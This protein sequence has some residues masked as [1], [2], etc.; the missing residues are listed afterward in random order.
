MTET[1]QFFFIPGF[2]LT[3]QMWAPVTRVL[4]E[5]ATALEIPGGLDFDAVVRSLAT[6]RTGIWVGY[7]M[8]GRI[9]LRLAL[10]HP[11]STKGLVLISATAGI[12]EPAARRKRREQDEK[13]ATD[14]ETRGVDW[15]LDYWTSLPLFRTTRRDR[16]D[17]IRDAG[18]IADQLRRLGQGVQRPD[19]S[20]LAE[21]NAPVLV[22]AGELDPAYAA[23]ARALGEAI[24]D[25]ATVSIVPGAGHA[26][27]HE[28]PGLVAEMVTALG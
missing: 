26:V 14:I 1:T 21:L 7:S 20:R 16:A 5:R 4:G 3:G 18:Q 23:T 28:A 2:A 11:T 6:G 17:R 12:A 25:N 22:V 27:V 19:W 9:A 24:G 8:G 13:L 15:F 10:D